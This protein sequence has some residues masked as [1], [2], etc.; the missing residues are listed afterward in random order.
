M[1]S[2]ADQGTRAGEHLQ[3]EGVRADKRSTAP[4]DRDLACIHVP[5]QSALLR[6]SAH[7]VP[8]A[9]VTSMANMLLNSP[10]AALPS[11]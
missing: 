5:Q 2:H 10:A 9:A 1:L 6:R 4:R 11:R 7:T 3:N 8:S